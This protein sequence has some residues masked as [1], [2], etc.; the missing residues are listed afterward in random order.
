MGLSALAC[1]PS[2]GDGTSSG[3]QTSTGTTTAV[4]EDAAGATSA[5]STTSPAAQTSSS[6]GGSSGP[7][8]DPV[9]C[10]ISDAEFTDCLGP[11]YPAENTYFQ[12]SPADNCDSLMCDSNNCGVCG[13]RCLGGC[14]DGA[15]VS[16]G[17]EC[18]EEEDGF[19]TCAQ[20]CAAEGAACEDQ[21]NSTQ[22]R[23]G[24]DR[25]YDWLLVSQFGLPGC[26]SARTIAHPNHVDI[27]CDEPIGWDHG[28]PEQ[29]LSSVSCCCKGD[30]M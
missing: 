22:D 14:L 25:G 23:Y 6:D 7:V 20:A 12:C 19:S 2:T 18:F 10:D 29:P 30:Q 9:P 16:A 11:P 1:G 26:A 17:S 21:L 15:C 24:C 5:T 3:A 4:T 13:Q 27:G 28:T 8:Y